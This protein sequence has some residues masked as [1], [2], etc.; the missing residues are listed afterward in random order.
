[1]RLV[2]AVPLSLRACF[3]FA[4]LAFVAGCA[5]SNGSAKEPPAKPNIVLILADDM[6][7]NDVGY[8]GSEIRTPA[9]DRLA[10]AGVRLEQFY[11]QSI[12]SPTRACLLTGRHTLRYG[13]QTGVVLPW[14]EYGLPTT[15]TTLAEALKSAGYSTAICGKWHVGHNEAKYLPTRRGFDRAYGYYNGAIDHFTHMRDEGLDWQRND[16]PLE[17]DGYATTLIAREAVRVIERHDDSKPLFLYVA[18]SAPH[19]PLQAPAEYLE[20]YRNIE[21][22]P[23]RRYAAMVTCMDDAI[24]EILR[25]LEKRGLDKQTLVLFLSDNGAE[26]HIGNN[27][28]YRGGKGELYEGGIR[29]PALASWP[30]VLA[31]RVV[32]EPLIAADLYPTLLSLAGAPPQN[33]PR[34][35]GLNAWPALSQGAALQRKE[36]L[37]EAS[38][39]RGAIRAGEWKLVF[40]GHLNGLEAAK[41]GRDTYELFNLSADPGERQDLAARY[42]KIRDGLKARL[43]AYQNQSIPPFYTSVETPPGYRAPKYWARFPAEKED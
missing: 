40:N 26:T 34:L 32:N 35:D 22:G 15:E 27:R 4:A 12:C 33:A 8:H 37:L 11:A 7:W 9:I 19:Q 25:T 38:A 21:N 30:G 1:M 42:P 23:R 41:R 24:A 5:P 14:A 17:E 13:F 43:E 39:V 3:L 16:S 2:R 6:G 10:K 36:I 20:R 18:F 31:S 28:P 29:V